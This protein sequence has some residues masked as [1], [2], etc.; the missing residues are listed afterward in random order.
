MTSSARPTWQYNS[1]VRACTATA[2]DVVPASAVLSMIL[3]RTPNR[4][5]HSANTKPVGPAPTIRTSVSRLDDG[6]ICLQIK[7]HRAIVKVC[8]Q[9]RNAECEILGRG[10][11][12][13][14][15]LGSRHRGVVAILY[16]EAVTELS[17]GACRI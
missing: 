16:S 6:C 1:S 11:D 17:T 8:R 14:N 7:A 13:G 3:T 12:I 5:S 15:T 2:R 9:L 10:Q 4:V